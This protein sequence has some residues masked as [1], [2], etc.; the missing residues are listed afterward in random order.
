MVLPDSNDLM[1]E[2]DL[3]L[4]KNDIGPPIQSF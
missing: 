2:I 1:G 3:Q 4:N